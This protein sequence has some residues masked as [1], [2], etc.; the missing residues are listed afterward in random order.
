[1]NLEE[2][3]LIKE[4]I[5]NFKYTSM[6]YMDFDELEAY[7]IIKMTSQLIL[8][9]TSNKY[10]YACDTLDHLIS[11]IEENAM[12]PFVHET[13]VSKM[14]DLGFRV[15]AH[16]QDYF[17]TSEV[18]YTPYQ[19]AK[20]EDSK[21]LSDITKACYNQSRGFYGE[22]VE[23]IENWLTTKNHNII[24]QYEDD[25]LVGLCCV[26]MYA[27]DK[28]PYLWI[29]EVA[30]HPEYQKKGYGRQLIAKGMTYGHDRGA[31]K[32][33][34]AADKL[35]TSAIKLY[36]SFGFK[37]SGDSQIDMERVR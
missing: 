3:K 4:K 33:F 20:L 28:G 37:A 34:L 16:Y 31:R 26:A 22:E 29:R 23:W 13:W 25:V 19:L 21:R 8:I 17:S 1:M 15:I 9:Q 18:E 5:K 7:N 24:A 27:F 2:F 30:V 6:T 10:H 12:I 32:A 11:S 36:E 14:E 35:N